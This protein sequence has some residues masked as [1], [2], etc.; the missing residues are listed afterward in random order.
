MKSFNVVKPKPKVGENVLYY[1]KKYDDYYNFTIMKV[2]KN[3]F[4]IASNSN[5]HKIFWN[6]VRVKDWTFLDSCVNKNVILGQTKHGIEY[7]LKMNKYI[8]EL[9]KKLEK[10][11]FTYSQIDNIGKAIGFSFQDYIDKGAE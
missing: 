10:G 8:S 4:Y 9:T 5:E 11:I 3:F 7:K 2:T 6:K 1:R